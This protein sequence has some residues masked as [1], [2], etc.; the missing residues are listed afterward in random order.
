MTDDELFGIRALKMQQLR[1]GMQKKAALSAVPIVE[2]FSTP[3]CPYCSMAKR[4]LMDKKIQFKDIDIT[5]DMAA[6]RRMMSISKQN[7]V[8]Q[9]RI[10]DSWIVGFDRHAIDEALVR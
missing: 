2:V 4:Y 1:M 8:P 7:G 9:I 3:T 6:A 10:N 5:K